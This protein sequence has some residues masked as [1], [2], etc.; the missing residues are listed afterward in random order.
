[1]NVR[2]L[3]IL[4]VVSSMIFTSGVALAWSANKID[5][6]VKATTGIALKQEI[7]RC[8]SVPQSLQPVTS[9]FPGSSRAGLGFGAETGEG[10]LI[11]GGQHGGLLPYYG[12]ILRFAGLAHRPNRL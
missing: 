2:K 5:R 3:T 9:C 12:G 7:E 11:V 6:E 8:R 4:A 1:M 10:A